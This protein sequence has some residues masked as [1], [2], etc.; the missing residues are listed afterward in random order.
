[1]SHNLRLAAIIGVG[2]IVGGSI[3]F[4]VQEIMVERDKVNDLDAIG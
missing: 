2:T 1:M 3:G 4:Y